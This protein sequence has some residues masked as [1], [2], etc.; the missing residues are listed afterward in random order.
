MKNTGNLRKMKVSLSEKGEVNYSL[1]LGEEEISM[2]SLIGKPLQLKYN[3]YI[4]CVSCGKE[5]KKAFGQGFCY[6]CFNDSPM[7][8][9]CIVRPELCEAHLGKGRDVAWEEKHHNRPHFVYLSYTSGLKV[10]VTR[11]DQI[12]TRW[13]DQGAVMAVI[14]A[15]TPYRQLAGKVEVALKDFFDD[16]THWQ[17]MLRQAE[18]P[19]AENFLASAL[20]AQQQ[21]PAYLQEYLQPLHEATEI[22]YPIEDFPKKISSKKLDK[23]PEME[24]TLKGIKG[25]YLYFEGG[26]VMNVRNH[27]GYHVT[28]EA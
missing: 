3:G 17:R 20:K 10:G 13:I 27:S 22:H 19:D 12:P 4:N 1:S 24:V 28:L 2:N 14:L 11:E 15:K 26:G 16:K 23:F 18:M 25:Q 8:S 7:N 6:P 21:I 9:P 5:I